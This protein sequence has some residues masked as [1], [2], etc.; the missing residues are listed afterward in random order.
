MRIRG[1]K[2]SDPGFGINIPDP[3]HWFILK[4]LE[5]VGRYLVPASLVGWRG[6]P[7]RACCRRPASSPAQRPSICPSSPT[8]AAS[9]LTNKLAM[10]SV[11]WNRSYLFRLRFWLWKCFG[12]A[13]G[14]RPNSF[15]NT[16]VV[17]NLTYFCHTI[18]CRIRI[19]MR[20][21]IRNSFGS[22]YD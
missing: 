21:R 20:N 5:C 16:N 8:C 6:T 4:V 1:G 3:Q 15:P 7:W 22:G 19:Q 17:Q 18:L 9:I 2:K 13:S 14:S 12:S 11:L 10:K